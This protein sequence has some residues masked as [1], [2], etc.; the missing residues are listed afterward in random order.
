[1]Q[2][3]YTLSSLYLVEV[4]CLLNITMYTVD[5]VIPISDT[6]SITPTTISAASRPVLDE[7][8]LTSKIE[9]TDDSKK[10]RIV[11]AINRKKHLSE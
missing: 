11:I 4:H 6:T 5:T 3:L 2:K 10:I 8:E 7:D 1:M 9:L